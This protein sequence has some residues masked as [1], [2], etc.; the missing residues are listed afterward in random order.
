MQI[1]ALNMLMKNREKKNITCFKE[2]HCRD[3]YPLQTTLCLTPCG[4]QRPV[5]GNLLLPQEE[6]R[7][8]AGALVCIFPLLITVYLKGKKT[9]KS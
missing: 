7:F 5:D 4:G 8:N 6:Q 9:W 1:Y 2:S 3:R